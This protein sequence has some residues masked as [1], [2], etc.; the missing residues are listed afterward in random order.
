MSTFVFN[1]VKLL[2]ALH[3]LN[4][5]AVHRRAQLH[6]RLR[7]PL[8]RESLPSWVLEHEVRVVNR[9]ASKEELEVQL[10][11][12]GKTLEHVEAEAEFLTAPAAL[13]R[14]GH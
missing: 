14:H 8:H 1:S 3:P 9:E 13:R 12:V 5:H 2:S 7:A 6:P 10:R 11:T 4:I